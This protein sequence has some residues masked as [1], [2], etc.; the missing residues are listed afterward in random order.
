MFKTKCNDFLDS[1]SKMR[2]EAIEKKVQDAL[3]KE[4]QPYVEELVKTKQLLISEETEKVEEE[5]KKLRENLKAK[6]ESYE[7]KT[8]KAIAADK[9]KV[10]KKARE[11]ACENY[12]KFILGVS[13]LVD[14]TQI[15]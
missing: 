14:E 13:R 11:L 9:E 7:E 6:V 8:N 4:H 15:N 1:I 5:V 2:E 3:Q 12:D 10:T